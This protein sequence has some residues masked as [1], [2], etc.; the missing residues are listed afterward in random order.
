MTTMACMLA[1]V[2]VLS[3]VAQLGSAIVCVGSDGHIDIESSVCTCCAPTASHDGWART[4][5]A[6]ANP[7]CS[8][9]VDVPLRVPPLKP[10]A[11]QLSTADIDAEG[12]MPASTCNGRSRFDFVVHA[13]HMDQ[14]PQS[15]LS[16]STVVL[17][18]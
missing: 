9:C 11:P 4:G 1:T 3:N 13:K 5:P 7:S 8:D 18:T 17:L 16:I 12:R 15:L 6:P 14:H 2:L 10:K